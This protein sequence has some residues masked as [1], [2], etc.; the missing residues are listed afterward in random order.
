[1]CEITE[2]TKPDFSYKI[3][4]AETYKTPFIYQK[5]FRSYR[6]VIDYFQ[7]KEY[8]SSDSK[9]FVLTNSQHYFLRQ[10]QVIDSIIETNGNQKPSNWNSEIIIKEYNELL[11]K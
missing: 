8:Y 7:I 1:M 3:I 2:I 6:E 5:I 11:N 10:G 4:K 9:N